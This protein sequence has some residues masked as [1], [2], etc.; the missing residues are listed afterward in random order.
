[1]VEFSVV[2]RNLYN[3]TLVLTKDEPYL[4]YV[5]QNGRETDLCILYPRHC[6]S[7]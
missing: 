6:N 7:C 4:T 2:R 5:L 3:L 1:M